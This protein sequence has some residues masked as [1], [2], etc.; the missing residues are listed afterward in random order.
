MYKALPVAAAFAVC[1]LAAVPTRAA[2]L[3]TKG[4]G[5][6]LTTQLGV[7]GLSPGR[8]YTITFATSAMKTRYTPYLTAAVAQAKAAGLKLAI[9]GV[10]P[11]NP[12]TCGPVGHIQFTE[13]YRPLGRPG[14]SQGMPCPNPPKGV[15][16]GGIVAIDSEYWDGTWPMPAYKLR[17][18]L[19]HEPLHALGLDHPNLDL[20][21]DGKTADYECAANPSGETPIMCSPNGGYRTATGMGR[22]TGFDLNGLKALLANARAQGIK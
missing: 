1:A 8:Q 6:K 10:E 20:N 17:N 12:A 3:A 4:T 2:T 5:W 19:V 7:T 18:T 11:V 15:G 13:L 9:G 16:T 14:F 21:K 22:L